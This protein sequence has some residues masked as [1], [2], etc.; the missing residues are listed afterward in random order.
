DVPRPIVEL[1]PGV[2]VK[3][4]A[5]EIGRVVRNLIDN[6]HRY[7]RRSVKVRV[8]STDREAII[9]VVDDGLGISTEDLSRIFD[10]FYRVRSDRGAPDGSGLGLAIAT[11]LARRNGGRIAAESRPGTGSTFRVVLPRFR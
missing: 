2:V 6:A 11:S 7:G 10:P 5:Q 9:E 8:I 3:A 1:D 4:D